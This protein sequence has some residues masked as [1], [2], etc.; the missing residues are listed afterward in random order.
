MILVAP[1]VG[2]IVLDSMGSVSLFAFATGSAVLSFSVFFA[3]RAIGVPRF[4]MPT[5]A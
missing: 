5:P 3:L 1:M 2:A 4:Q